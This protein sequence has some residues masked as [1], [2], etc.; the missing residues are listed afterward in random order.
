MFCSSLHPPPRRVYFQPSV[1]PP[2]MSV[3]YQLVLNLDVSLL[4]Q[5]V[6]PMKN[7][8]YSSLRCP[9]TC[10]FK[11]LSERCLA[12]CSFCCTLTVLRALNWDCLHL[13]SVCLWKPLVQLFVSCC[14]SVYKSQCW[15]CLSTCV[16]YCTW[17]WIGDISS[18]QCRAVDLLM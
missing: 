2:D 11:Q 1:L 18:D 13:R 12:N 5:P 4:Q 15:T 9:W 10:L 14:V 3:R 17:T 7:L 8:S 6:L 16:L